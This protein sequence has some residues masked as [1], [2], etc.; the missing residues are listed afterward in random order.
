MT[1]WNPEKE[2]GLHNLAWLYYD[3]PGAQIWKPGTINYVN[4]RGNRN[5]LRTR[6]LL[7]GVDEGQDKRN[8][9]TTTRQ[10]IQVFIEWNRTVRVCLVRVNATEF[11]YHLGERDVP[12][13][14]IIL[15]CGVD[16]ST[17][18]AHPE[19]AWYNAIFSNLEVSLV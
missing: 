14:P 17:D 2:D 18:P 9:G 1:L 3:L 10:P 12:D 11:V 6:T 7:G 16:N 4:L 19:A 8:F 15:Q 5:V 13:A